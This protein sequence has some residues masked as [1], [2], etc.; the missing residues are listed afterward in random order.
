MASELSR[1]KAAVAN[2]RK[3]GEEVEALIV[4]KAV[5]TMAGAATGFA[6]SKGLAPGYFGVPTKLGIATVASLLEALTRDKSLRRFLGA[7]GDAE[8]AAYSYS[9]AKAQAFV[10]GIGDGGS[11]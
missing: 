7:I 3:R 2:A 10:A 6:E 11:L 8:L 4:R 5:I 1:A 9:A